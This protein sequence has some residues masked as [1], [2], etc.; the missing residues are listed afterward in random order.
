MSLQQDY[1]N[2]KEYFARYGCSNWGEDQGN[3]SCSGWLLSDFD[4]WH[5][6]SLHYKGQPHPDEIDDC[7][8]RASS[9]VREKYSDKSKEYQDGA[10]SA[11]IDLFIEEA[12]NRGL[13]EYNEKVA[14]SKPL[15][16]DVPDDVPF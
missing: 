13:R 9:I 10:E 5:K 1:E 2:A 7:Y 4:T 15:Y 6:C 14:N 8:G 11:L 16:H 3:P 12:T